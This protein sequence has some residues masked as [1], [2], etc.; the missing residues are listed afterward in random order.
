MSSPCVH[1]HAQA[2]GGVG[3]GSY[4]GC[5]QCVC[6]KVSRCW[7]GAYTAHNVCEWGPSGST[8]TTFPRRWAWT[9]FCACFHAPLLEV[10]S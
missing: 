5:P 7:P 8:A 9:A 4:L 2:P 3:L 10:L 6:K 1:R